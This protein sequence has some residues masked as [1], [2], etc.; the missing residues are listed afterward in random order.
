MKYIKLFKFFLIFMY[1]LFADPDS[2]NLNEQ[3][4]NQVMRGFYKLWRFIG[5]ELGVRPLEKLTL[6]RM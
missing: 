1:F 2:L 3:D 6:L 4:L 5:M